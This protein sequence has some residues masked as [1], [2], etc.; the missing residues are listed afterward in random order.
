MT[1]WGS[2]AMGQRMQREHVAAGRGLERRPQP[3]PVYEGDA[4]Q[5]NMGTWCS[6]GGQRGFVK[7]S[8][9]QS[10]ADVAGR[11]WVKRSRN[12]QVQ[13]ADARVV[14]QT[15]RLQSNCQ[16]KK[17]MTPRQNINLRTETHEDGDTERAE[18]QST[19]E[20]AKN[21]KSCRTCDAIQVVTGMA[22]AG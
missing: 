15:R 9:I 18:H 2:P 17:R 21:Q 7:R 10:L 6:I 11:G 3:V 12:R 8:V 1:T 14:S 16:E 13:N 19:K 20:D 22:G 4:I 5:A